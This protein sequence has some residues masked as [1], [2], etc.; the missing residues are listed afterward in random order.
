MPEHATSWIV[1]IAAVALIGACLAYSRH[2]RYTARL[3]R[4]L[5]TI[6]LAKSWE[7]QGQIQKAYRA[8]SAVCEGSFGL[9]PADL[10]RNAYDRVL[11]LHRTIIAAHD[12]TLRALETY[13]ARAGRYP[14]NLEEVQAEIPP[15]SLAAFRGF[16]YERKG[17]SDLSI[18]TGLYGGKDEARA[19]NARNASRDASHRRGGNSRTARPR[20][21]PIQP[22]H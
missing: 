11:A 16:A 10:P 17:D 2:R 19:K 5:Q 3:Q 1:L 9:E 21:A 6:R 13:R 4:A 7:R 18:V 14:D 8:Y 22:I 12:D 15:E 20:P